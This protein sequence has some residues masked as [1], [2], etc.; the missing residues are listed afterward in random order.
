MLEAGRSSADLW[1]MWAQTQLLAVVHWLGR[2]VESAGGTISS[3]WRALLVTAGMG[4]TW[5]A[6]AA[7]HSLEPEFIQAMAP[8]VDSLAWPLAVLLLAWSFQSQVVAFTLEAALPGLAHPIITGRIVLVPEPFTRLL[9]GQ[10]Q[11]EAIE[12]G[13]VEPSIL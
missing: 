5:I 9:R 1:G 4:V 3:W 8:V 7:V 12:M 11:T 2:W 13:N 6:A 10:R